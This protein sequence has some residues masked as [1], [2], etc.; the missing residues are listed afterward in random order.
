MTEPLFPTVVFNAAMLLVVAQVFDLVAE[1]YRL[2][3][4]ERRQWFAG[5]TLGA[6]GIGVM[7]A[8]LTLAPGLVFDVR[9]VLLAISGL[10][11]GAVPTAIAMAMT[12]AYRLYLGGPGAAMGVAVILASGTIGV[13]WRHRRRKPLA[14]IGWGEL[15]VLGLVVHAVMLALLVFLP[16]E[17]M[18]DVL[19]RI[20]LP[21]I[22]VYPVLTVVLGALLTGRLRRR[23][24]YVSLRES[25]A[26]FREDLRL[27]ARRRA[28]GGD[29]VGCRLSGP[30]VPGRRDATV[31]F[32]AR[33]SRCRCGGGRAR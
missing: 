6:V 3:T 28:V 23:K 15:Y 33:A 20:G 2:R 19:A 29:L 30:D 24:A 25:E 4:L 7:M 18:G 9:S 14:D 26:R 16:R 10:F 21:V 12:V 8:P 1:R 31:E 5:V 17:V 13:A 32:R 27:H 11:F 22:V